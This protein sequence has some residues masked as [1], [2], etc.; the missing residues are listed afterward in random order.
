MMQEEFAWTV[1]RKD[2]VC[3][4]IHEVRLISVQRVL[5]EVR[6]YVVMRNDI[7]MY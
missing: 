1:W 5:Y 2:C 3:G 6:I 4:D 7:R